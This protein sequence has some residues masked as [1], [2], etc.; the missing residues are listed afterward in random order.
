MAKGPYTV[1]E[2]NMGKLNGLS[3]AQIELHL[4]LYRGY[5][6]N[7]NNLTDTLQK[8][9]ADGQAGTTAYVEQTRRLGF[10]YGGMILHE[11]YFGG[12]KG[13]SAPL[14][15][16]SALGKA[17]ADSFGSVDTWLADFKAI[18]VFRG[19]GWV[20]TFQDPQT[21]WL[22]NHWV[23]EHHN[24]VPASFRPVV[25]MDVWEH[26]FLVDYKPAERAKYIEAYLSNVDWQTCQQRL[27]TPSAQ[28]WSA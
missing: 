16:N 21:G 7:V 15:N 11:Y 13:G 25:V 24:G 12:M 28:R 4:G 6:T 3:D 10:E 19:I 23:D 26:A 17:L 18:G 2:F 14:D 27:A 5:V 22:S 8:A 9:Q 20:I 1:R